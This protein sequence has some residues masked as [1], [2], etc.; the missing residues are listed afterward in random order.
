MTKFIYQATNFNIM[1]A[2]ND[3]FT[4]T[5]S[6]EIRRKCTNWYI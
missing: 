3:K 2:F 6:Q 1:F 4:Q 5:E